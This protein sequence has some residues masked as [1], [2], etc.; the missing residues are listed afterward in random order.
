MEAPER[1]QKLASPSLSKSCSDEVEEMLK[2]SEVNFNLL[3]Q[4]PHPIVIVGLDRRI[5]RVNKAL[6]KLTGY[7]ASELVGLKTPY[8][9]WTDQDPE[10][11]S[12]RDRK[13]A[14][15]RKGVSFEEKFRKKSGEIF[16][17][18]VTPMAILI[19]GKPLYYMYMWTD[20]TKRKE[21]EEAQR[22]F[23][24][25]RS[26]F[27]SNVSHELR[28]PLHSIRGFNK[29]MLEGRVPDEE[30]QK[31]FLSIVDKQSEKLDRLISSLLDMSRLECGRFKIQ[32]ERLSLKE[33]IQEVVESFYSLAS[34]K[35]IV[36]TQEIEELPEVEADR[37][38]MEQ[39]MANLL[40]NAI[41]FSHTGGSILIKGEVKD[42]EILV[43][44]IDHGIGIDKEALPHLFKRFFRAESSAKVGGTGLGLY[45]SKQIIEAHGGRI[46][47]ESERGKGTTVS[48]TLPLNSAGGDLK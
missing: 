18:E 25:M 39:V 28:S 23:D 43:K 31:E 7:C 16:W 26:E 21:M 36:I 27:F 13:A 48:F 22:E 1:R 14:L 45:I 4:S 44:V 6:E 8:P 34:D 10:E 17:V 40:S 20:I 19:D 30:T 41:K 38:R 5:K 2:E 11:K 3:E 32:K 33:V 24:R 42:G 12:R 46:W 47:V 37:E 9:W 35:G 29:L 15:E